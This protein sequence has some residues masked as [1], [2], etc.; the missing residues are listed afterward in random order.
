MNDILKNTQECYVLMDPFSEEFVLEQIPEL[1][2]NGNSVGC[3]IS[4][5]TGEDWRNDF[6]LM[7]PFLVEKQWGEWAGEYFV[8]ETTT[9]IVPI[10]K[11][12]ID[13]MAEWGCDWVEFD[14]MD[15]AVD[16]KNRRRYQFKATPDDGEKYFQEL[17]DYTH[18]QGILCM[19]KSTR[20]G[21]E[22]FDGITIESS[23]NDKN[24]WEDET[25]QGF[26]DEGK[27]TI[28]VHYEELRCEKVYEEYLLRYDDG[29]SF[30]CEDRRMRE[31]MHFNE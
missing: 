21:A 7:K 25:L 30:I 14:N 5:G 27:L 23:Y 10:M 3:Y 16:E 31:Y 8:S 17:C 15:W 28:I 19:A 9:G 4:V 22:N 18:E 24:W 29:L 1:Q 11:E 2:G 12:R 26:L 20:T 13:Q 6:S